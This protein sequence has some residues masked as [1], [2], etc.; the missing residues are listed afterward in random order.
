MIHLDKSVPSPDPVK[1]EVVNQSLQEAAPFLQK[2]TAALRDAGLKE[3]QINL[4]QDKWEWQETSLH[5]Q[6]P[7]QQ[8]LHSEIARLLDQTYP[9]N[10][11]QFMGMYFSRNNQN[12]VVTSKIAELVD[13]CRKRDR[14]EVRNQL[15]ALLMAFNSIS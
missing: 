14:A 15:N 6:S 10:M 8:E 12:E 9:G 5:R 4:T 7:R 13:V 1:L 11:G 2:V 3:F